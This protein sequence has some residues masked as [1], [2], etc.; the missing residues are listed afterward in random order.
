VEHGQNGRSE[1]TFTDGSNGTRKKNYSYRFVFVLSEEGF[2]HARNVLK[3][4]SPEN[5]DLINTHRGNFESTP[6]GVAFLQEKLESEGRY[7]PRSYKDDPCDVPMVPSKGSVPKVKEIV[8]ASTFRIRY[9]AAETFYKQYDS[10]NSREGVNGGHV[11]LVGDAA[12]VH[13]PAGGQGMNLGIRDGL[14]CGKAIAEHL[15]AEGGN[16]TTLEGY[17]TKRRKEA[18][19]IITITKRLSRIASFK[20]GSLLARG[21]DLF[22]WVI[23]KVLGKKFVW[24]IS[25]LGR[26]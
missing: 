10:P 12:H 1:Q 13:S 25:G 15:R 21:R 24:T 3:T 5:P 2:Q 17:A 6:E 26:N 4:K 11:L 20:S 23:G 9:A 8:W 14:E 19:D 16:S 18:L 22:V 7:I